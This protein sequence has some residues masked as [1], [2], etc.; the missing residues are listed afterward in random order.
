[1][2]EIDLAAAAA[3]AAAAEG[4]GGE[5]GARRSSMA[6]YCSGPVEAGRE[7]IIGGE[8]LRVLPPLRLVAVVLRGPVE[9]FEWTDV[10]DGGRY[11]TE[12]VMI[13]GGCGRDPFPGE[14]ETIGDDRDDSSSGCAGDGALSE[15][16]SESVSGDF[17]VI[18]GSS[19][20]SPGMV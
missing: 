1:M 8:R 15:L 3:A 17:F 14:D 5:G 19:C 11:G 7:V 4:F 18:S 10:V 12:L 2:R 16:W 20:V 6:P 9:P 13:G